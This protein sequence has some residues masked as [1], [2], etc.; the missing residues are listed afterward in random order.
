MLETNLSAELVEKSVSINHF[1]EVEIVC[2]FTK[3][4][5]YLSEKEY[6]LFKFKYSHL[7]SFIFDALA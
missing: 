2:I 5:A 6:S 3:E 4:L 7:F 1:N